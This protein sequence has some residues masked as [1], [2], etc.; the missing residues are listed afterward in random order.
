MRLVSGSIALALALVAGCHDAPDP[1]GLA[2]RS[3]TLSRAAAPTSPVG[4]WVMLEG[5]TVATLDARYHESDNNEWLNFDTRQPA[6]G[7]AVNG[8]AR[9]QFAAGRTRAN[10]TLTIPVGGGVLT[11]DLS[12]LDGMQQP[13]F[14]QIGPG[15]GCITASGVLRIQG[16][17]QVVT[18]MLAWNLQ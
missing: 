5:T 17:A 8:S 16:Q 12:Q 11:V 13:P 1:T 7:V 10:G 14:V 3:P 15:G 4:V 9:V 2:A 6:A 18:V